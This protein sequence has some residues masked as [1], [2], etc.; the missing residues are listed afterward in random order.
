MSSSHPVNN[1]CSSILEYSC[2]TWQNLNKTLTNRLESVKS[3]ALP[4]YTCI[5]VLELRT[6]WPPFPHIPSHPR[7]SSW[8]L[9]CGSSVQTSCRSLLLS[10]YLFQT[11][12]PI[13]D[14]T[15]PVCSTSPLVAFRSVKE[16]SF[17]LGLNFGISYLK[18]L[19]LVS[20][21][22]SS[23][24]LSRLSPWTSCLLWYLVCLLFFLFWSLSMF[25][26]CCSFC[27]SF[28]Y[29]ILYQTQ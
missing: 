7:S 27:F 5:A 22:L 3:F 25:I 26:F 12:V 15:I 17:I 10:V 2:A 9:N 8:L 16:A 6:S 4:G 29:V 28:R 23:R 1:P 18:M 24:L 21:C 14:V 13:Q 20:L 19:R 11:V